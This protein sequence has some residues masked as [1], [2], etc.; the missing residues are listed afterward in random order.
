MG[1][2]DVSHPRRYIFRVTFFVRVIRN[3]RV[4]QILQL[5]QEPRHV[6]KHVN[7]GVLFRNK[8]ELRTP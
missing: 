2:V 4:T 6:K 3:E 1:S 5:E 7:D 8:T